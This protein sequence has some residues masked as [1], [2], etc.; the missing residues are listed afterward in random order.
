[1]VL[2]AT[3][4]DAAARAHYIEARHQDTY[5]AW[6]AD[7]ITGLVRRIRALLQAQRPHMTLAVDVFAHADS[8]YRGV[9]QD[10]RRWASEGLVDAVYPM[11]YRDAQRLWEVGDY[12]RDTIAALDQRA[13]S[14]GQRRA[15]LVI[16][17]STAW[18]EPLPPDEA[19]T[20]IQRALANGADGIALQMLPYWWQAQY[21]QFR[22]HYLPRSAE[23]PALWDYDAMLRRVFHGL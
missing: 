2:P 17:L 6:R 7:E 16:G 21:A 4:P 3:L 23:W 1:M 13:A 10:W 14:A 19:A 12:V 9:S 15:A 22:Q 11:F 5:V 8:A 18:Y 20:L